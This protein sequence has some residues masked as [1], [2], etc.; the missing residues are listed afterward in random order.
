LEGSRQKDKETMADSG[1]NA[2]VEK[3]TGIP[4]LLNVAKTLL[5][6]QQ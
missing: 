2:I 1:V 6:R 5:E 3:P 4:E